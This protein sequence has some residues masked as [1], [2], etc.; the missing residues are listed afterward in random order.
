MCD[1]KRGDICVKMNQ[2][3]YGYGSYRIDSEYD[4]VTDVVH[5]KVDAV[6]TQMY[7]LSICTK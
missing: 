7:Q 3:G 2:Y 5:H 1:E 6:N 4:S